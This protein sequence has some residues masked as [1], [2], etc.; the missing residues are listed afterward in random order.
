MVILQISGSG[1]TGLKFYFIP[2]FFT[3]SLSF[4]IFLPFYYRIFILSNA[5]TIVDNYTWF[6][7]VYAYGYYAALNVCRMVKN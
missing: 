5:I 7:T 6:S 2:G 4:V 1:S 3:L